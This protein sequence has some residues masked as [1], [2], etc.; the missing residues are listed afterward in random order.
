LATQVILTPAPSMTAFLPIVEEYRTEKVMLIG[1]R[2][3]D[4]LPKEL[5]NIYLAIAGLAGT[6]SERLHYERELN[7]HRAHLEELV[8][9]RTIELEAANKELEA[10][11]YSV[12]HD[13][14]APLRIIKGMADI[15]FNDYYDKL[16]DEGKELIK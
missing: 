12:S 6:T 11:S 8:K 13:L 10:F 15:L 16:D 7:R 1:H 3:T 5:L 14:R 9:G 2:N 4:P